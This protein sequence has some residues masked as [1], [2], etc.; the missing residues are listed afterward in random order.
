[1]PAEGHGTALALTE[2][3]RGKTLFLRSRRLSDSIRTPGG[4]KRLKDIYRE[5]GVSEDSRDK[6]P[7][8][9]VGDEVAAVFG[10][11]FG[12]R[13]VLAEGYQDFPA[14]QAGDVLS[15]QR[16]ETGIGR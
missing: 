12:Y 13:D 14:Q 3:S 4:S 15:I 6:I 10:S 8:L 2:S 7:V 9:Q 5:L 1:M 11:L 16:M